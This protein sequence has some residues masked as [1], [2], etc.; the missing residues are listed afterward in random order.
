MDTAQQTCSVKVVGHQVGNR[1]SGTT[2]LGK[3]SGGN[4]L[5]TAKTQITAR[6]RRSSKYPALVVVGIAEYTLFY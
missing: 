3:I 2:L 5:A 1:Y 4:A 6:S